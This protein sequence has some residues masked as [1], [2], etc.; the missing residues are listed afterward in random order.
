MVPYSISMV[1]MKYIFTHTP[2]TSYDVE[3]SKCAGR[4]RAPTGLSSRRQ[5]DAF[6]LRAERDPV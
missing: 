2:R 3:V 4:R 6:R 5:G 1:M